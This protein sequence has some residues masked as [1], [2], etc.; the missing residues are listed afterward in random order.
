MKFEGIIPA[1]ITPFEK[2]GRTVNEKVARQ[3]V[4]YQLEQGADGFYIVGST[5]EGIVMDEEQR[6]R[7]CETVVSQVSGRKPVICHIASMNFDEAL[8]LAKH[9]EKTGADALS[10]I[11][12][13]FFHYRE[14]DIYN[15]YKTLAESTELPFIMYNHPAANGG[16]SAELVVKMFK[17]IDNI[18]GVKWTINN[19]YEMMHLK[20]L[21]DGEM[22][23]INGPDEMLLQ[24]LS[25]GADAGIGTMYNIMLPQFLQIFQLFKE[26][27]TEEARIVQEKVNNVI[28]CMLKHEGIPATKH[29]CK[30]LG[31]DV[32]T[33]KYPMAQYTEIEEL[34]LE[35]DLNLIGWPF[36]K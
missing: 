11:P 33:A 22:N 15:Y 18:T 29:M 20:S 21:T 7:M 28:R 26:N 2:D 32:G 14:K 35:N 25:A 17:E 19:Y 16:M 9:A 6:M 12:P 23:I 10:A 36:S 3:L 24:G 8:R 4:E 34:A 31:F 13:I 30:M 1:L 27:K 5:G